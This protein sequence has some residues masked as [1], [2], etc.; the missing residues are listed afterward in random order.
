[1]CKTMDSMQEYQYLIRVTLH[2]QKATKV[3]SKFVVKKVQKSIWLYHLLIGLDFKTL[4]RDFNDAFIIIHNNT[5][6]DTLV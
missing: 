1:M 6:C 3:V 5:L 4:I 2:C